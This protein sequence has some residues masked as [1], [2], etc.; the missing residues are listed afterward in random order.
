MCVVERYSSRMFEFA[1]VLRLLNRL[2]AEGVITDYAIAGAMA[3]AFWDE[4][5]A[6]QDLDVA[7]TFPTEPSS[8][9]P[10]RPIFDRLP[11]TEY[12]RSGEHIIIAGVPVQFIPAWSP[13][14]SEAV[15]QAVE[16]PY[17]TVHSPGVT[18]RVMTPTHLT[19]IWQADTGAATP[20]RKE[21]MA[22]FREA[23]LIDEELLKQL[24]SRHTS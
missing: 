23:G 14:V 21:R 18:L 16:V 10:L 9:D 2:K 8:L 7:M 4:A 5:T 22:R 1:D 3:A 17:D 19:A 15:A 12:P 20:R 6:T 13:L 24:L 11:G